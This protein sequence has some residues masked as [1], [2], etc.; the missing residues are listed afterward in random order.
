MISV[1]GHLTFYSNPRARKSDLYSDEMKQIF[2]LEKC[3]N[4]VN[5]ISNWPDYKA[6]LLYSLQNLAADIQV[7]KIWYKDESQR[8]HLKSFKALGGAYAVVRQLKS[9][10]KKLTGDEPSTQDLLDK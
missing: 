3:T 1:K 7:D 8:F 10:I 5:E 9:E 4:A 2:S 6:T